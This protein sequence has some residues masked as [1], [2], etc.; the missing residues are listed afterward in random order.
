MKIAAWEEFLGLLALAVSSLRLGLPLSLF[1]SP[2][3]RLWLAA[4]EQLRRVVDAAGDHMANLFPLA[5]SGR[6]CGCPISVRR[7]AT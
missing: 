7:S 3:P 2:P 1:L 5:A 4:I 6:G